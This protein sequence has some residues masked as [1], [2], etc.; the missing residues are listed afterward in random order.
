MDQSSQV[1]FNDILDPGWSCHE[2]RLVQ[3]IHLGYKISLLIWMLEIL[4]LLELRPYISRLIRTVMEP[5]VL[6]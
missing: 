4:T 3:Q 1:H 5:C 6:E 2:N